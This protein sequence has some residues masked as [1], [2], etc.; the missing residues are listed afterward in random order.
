M[1]IQVEKMRKEFAA[2]DAIRDEGLKE[3]ESVEKIRNLSYGPYGMENIFDI[4]FP[5]HTDTDLPTIV[6]IH[7]GGFFYGDKELY[8]FYTM[9]LASQGF[10]VINMNYRLAPNSQYPA[11]LEDINALM[12]WLITNAKE[13]PIDLDHLFLVGDSAGAQ[14]AEQYAT[15]VTNPDYAKLFSFEAALVQL[16]AIAL[17]C[18]VYFI[19]ENQLINQDF[20]FYFGEILSEMTKRQFPVETYLTKNFPPSF[21]MTA[22]HDFLKEHAE[23]LVKLLKEKGAIAEYHLYVQPDGSELGHVFHIDQKSHVA[24][25]CNLDEIAFFKKRCK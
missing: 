8:R 18:G 11:P 9:F 2:T 23:P 10:T 25:Q 6:S 12:N 1:D 5:T 22:S 15:I 7:G 24:K 4:Y 14:L 19:G 13:Y 17:N 3:P 21:V 16:R 20:P